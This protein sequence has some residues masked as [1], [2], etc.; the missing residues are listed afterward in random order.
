[1]E[2]HRLSSLGEE[3]P[4]RTLRDTA[5]LAESLSPSLQARVGAENGR[6]NKEVRDN[7]RSRSADKGAGETLLLSTAFPEGSPMNPSYGSV[8]ATVAGA[9]VTV[10]KAIFDHTFKLPFAY[11]A[12]S[13]GEVLRKTRLPHRLT[14]EG[15]L[16][17]L[18]G[19]ISIGCS[20]AGVHYY[21]DYFESI[22][23]GEQIAIAIL[24]EQK[25]TYPE[26]FSMTLPKF[27]G[28]SVKI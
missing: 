8:H 25:L 2:R 1:M 10:L 19:N 15:E 23:M 12:S 4:D 17:K 26:S 9:C 18:A 22:M 11:E 7:G 28:S 14:I 20:W 13:N 3:N 21:S 27:D 6:Q 5:R 24:K 16:N